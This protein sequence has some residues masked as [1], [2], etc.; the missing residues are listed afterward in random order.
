MTSNPNSTALRAAA[1]LLDRDGWCQRVSQDQ[2]GRHCMQAAI[3][4]SAHPA[5]LAW[6]V[7]KIIWSRLDV[8]DLIGLNDRACESKEEA[9]LFLLML[10]AAVE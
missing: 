2:Y 9:V 10:A 6:E 4:V 7:F 5:Q 3:W 8:G 1:E